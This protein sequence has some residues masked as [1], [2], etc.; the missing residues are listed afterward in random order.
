MNSLF[1][2]SLFSNQQN[3]KVDV[4][5]INDNKNIELPDE[6]SFTDLLNSVD[7][8]EDNFPPE[9]ESP[10][11]QAM[12]DQN[13]VPYNNKQDTSSY[14]LD[15][16]F[17]DGMNP[18]Q[19]EAV[20]Y[21]E[22]SLL[23][24]AGAGSGKTR[25]ITHRFA[26][27]V[28]KYDLRIYNILCVTFTNKA[29]GEMKERIGHLLGVNTRTAWVRTFHSMCAMILREH[30]QKIGFSQDF[31]IYDSSDT[32]NTIKKIMERLKIDPKE[33]PDKMIARVISL[34][35]EELISPQELEKS[36]HGEFNHLCAE[37]Y[38]EYQQ[39]LK[40]NQAMDF[41]D[42]ITNTIILLEQCPDVRERYQRQ[43]RYIMADE[44]QDTNKPQYHLLS[45]LSRNRANVCVVG[46]DDQSIYAW[47]GAKVANI[48]QFHEE[49]KAHIVRLERNYRSY[50][51]ILLAA[52]SIVKSI[53]GRM[54]KTLKAERADGD[55]I[56]F[57][58]L[59]DDRIQAAYIYEEIRKQ[60]EQ[61]KSYKDFAILYRTNAQSRVLEE[62][63]TRH[64]IPHRIY[65][66]QRFFDRAEIKDI[67]SYLR[68]MVN[69]YDVEAFERAVNVPKRKV[70]NVGKQRIRSYVENNNISYP[71]ACLNAETIEGLTKHASQN[72]VELGKIIIE[73]KE[74]IDKL[75]PT[76][77]IKILVESIRY[78]EDYLIPEYGTH[79]AEDRFD[80]IQELVNAVKVF[81]QANPQASIADFL[82][83]A[84]LLSSL[85]EEDVD[86]NNTVTLMTIHSSKGLEFPIVFV[87]GL[88]E[89]VLPLTSATTQ[90]AE[91]EEK[92]LLYV[93]ITRAM[94]KL[95]LTY[96]ERSLRYGEFVH[97]EKSHFLD[98]IP[99]E[100]LNVVTEKSS[101]NKK[102]AYK[103]NNESYR[104]H[105]TQA[106]SGTSNYSKY[107]SKTSTA[108]STNSRIK[109]STVQDVLGVDSTSIKTVVITSVSEL[110]IGQGVI[111]SVFGK[112]IVEYSSSAMVRIAF[113]RFGTQV[114]MGSTVLNLKKIEE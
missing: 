34:A 58:R 48:R 61:G 55:K 36:S 80:N 28:Q 64:S 94:N 74:S 110:N 31:T 56:V 57:N 18:E 32:K 111:H 22:G 27:L 79:E 25:V 45:L 68:I 33:H 105:Y 44:F 88:A 86:E 3:K 69:P 72:L 1:S 41:G 107:T 15:P 4:E 87:I 26:H 101:S 24:L 54:P 40:Q 21:D 97:N 19:K 96:E 10:F 109:T 17:L 70:G 11:D 99:T 50:G 114:L 35:K 92:R 85:N 46:D 95:Y 77:I 100:I 104:N 42:L 53:K 98:A 13:F 29:A 49:F 43:W 66:G 23:V 51:N 78:F 84:S 47:R 62:V 89:G 67:L 37:I 6:G 9:E 71:I 63:M 91:D 20:L 8:S 93:A 5:P 82:R 90:E 73:L 76:Q 112:G 59:G 2:D 108:S 83:E 14:K 60:V 102:D 81:E 103:N 30:A 7:M 106:K 12:T 113:D 75:S 16:N 38:K 65:G 52:N 39:T